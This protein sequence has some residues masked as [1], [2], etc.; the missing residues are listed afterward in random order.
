MSGSVFAKRVHIQY[1]C[2]IFEFCY[3]ELSYLVQ[4]E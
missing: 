1:E 2:F 4:S 3:L